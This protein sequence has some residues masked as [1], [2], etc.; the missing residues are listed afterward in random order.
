MSVKQ[1][2]LDSIKYAR[3]ELGFTLISEDWGD[4]S[5]KCAC[6]LGCVLL[7]DD[8]KDGVQSKPKDNCSKAATLLGVNS[9][10]IDCFIDGFDANGSAL[11]APNAEAWELGLEIAKETKPISFYSLDGE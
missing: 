8:P 4:V 9:K 7:Q 6:A 3:E 11:T 10:W 2:I 5:A 1:K